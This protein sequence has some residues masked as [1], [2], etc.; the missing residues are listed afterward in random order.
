MTVPATGQPYVSTLSATLAQDIDVIQ[1]SSHMHK[2]GTNF[3]ATATL[4][5]GG[6]EPLY[7]TTSWDQPR[8]ALFPTPI[9]LPQGTTI[10][11]SC[12]DVNTT[13]TTLTFGE[14]AQTNVMCISINIF[15]PVQN[16]DNP[17]LGATTGGIGGL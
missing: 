13:G 15:Y 16:I 10:T 9:H 12:T 7:E 14:Y 11:W 4:P 5:D 2:F 17:V 8:P 1:S 6:T 3:V